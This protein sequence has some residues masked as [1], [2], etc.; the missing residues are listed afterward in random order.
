MCFFPYFFSCF[1]SLICK[2]LKTRRNLSSN[3]LVSPS[4]KERSFEWGA[5]NKCWW[6]R[7]F[8]QAGVWSFIK[9]LSRAEY[10]IPLPLLSSNLE[11]YKG[12]SNLWGWGMESLPLVLPQ[13]SYVTLICFEKW[14]Y[15][16]CWFLIY[17]QVLKL[18]LYYWRAVEFLYS[19]CLCQVILL[20]NFYSLGLDFTPSWNLVIIATI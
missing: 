13:A 7:S 5:C 15:W 6:H 3:S 14:G 17:L 4:S 2:Q 8:I 10:R 1:L 18:I 11:S 20:L 9:N 16:T 12:L 19:I